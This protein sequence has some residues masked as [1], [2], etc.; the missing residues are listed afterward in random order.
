[1]GDGELRYRVAGRS[2]GGESS[3]DGAAMAKMIGGGGKELGLFLGAAVSN[4]S[5]TVQGDCEPFLLGI[6]SVSEA[7]L[8][9][10]QTQVCFD[11][12]TTLGMSARME[13]VK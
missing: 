7:A 2:A 6:R 5:P 4:G 13:S 9:E 11:L 3:D 8:F 1:M 12:L 10:S